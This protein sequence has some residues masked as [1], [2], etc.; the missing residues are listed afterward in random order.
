MFHLSEYRVHLFELPDGPDS[1]KHDGDV[2][3]GRHC[4]FGS[5]QAKAHGSFGTSIVALEEY[6]CGNTDWE[7]KA[8]KASR[9]LAGRVE[10]NIY[11]ESACSEAQAGRVQEEDGWRHREA[12]LTVV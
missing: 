3:G 8:K 7:R 11:V 2:P 12:K 9:S 5:R 6:V 4:T 1:A 10:R